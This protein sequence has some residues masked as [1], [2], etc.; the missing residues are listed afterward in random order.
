MAEN[1]VYR[2]FLKEQFGYYVDTEADSR[3]D[4]EYKITKRLFDKDN[5]LVP[6]ENHFA[7]S[8]YQVDYAA[9]IERENAHL[10]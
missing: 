8:G 5:D 3:Q 1:K 7:H 10:E 2:V 6:I 9:R 4:A